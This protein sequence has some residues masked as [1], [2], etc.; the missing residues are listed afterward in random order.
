MGRPSRINVMHKTVDESNILVDSDSHYDNTVAND[1]QAQRRFGKPWM[2]MLQ[3][4]QRI[5][6]GVKMKILAKD[7][8]PPGPA[9][10]LAPKLHLRSC[11]QAVALSTKRR[12]IHL[13]QVLPQV[14]GVL[15]TAEEELVVVE[16][17]RLVRFVA[18]GIHGRLPQ[19]VPIQ[20]LYTAGVLGHLDA[21]ARFHLLKQVKF[22]TYAR[23]LIRGIIL[24]SLRALDWSPRTLRHKGRAVE[25]A[26]Q[27][28]TAQLQRSPTK[29]EIATK[30]D[31]RLVAYQ[32]LLGELKGLE[33]ETL[34]SERSGNSEE[35]SLIFAPS[36]PEDNP[37]S[38]T[39]LRRCGER[40]TRVSTT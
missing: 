19:H 14:P 7:S 22:R 4:G 3:F 40:L 13:H 25:Q 2:T 31:M 10:V 1:F 24:D 34:N 23:F 5:A 33:I 17:L 16:H 29:I 30:L 32:Q 12:A 6:V 18:R 9:S 39:W 38:A 15:L 26:I 11:T 8:R 20:D 35:G 37:L 21:F 36:R 27:T 28:L